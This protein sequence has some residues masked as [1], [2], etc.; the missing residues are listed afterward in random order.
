MS[1]IDLKYLCTTIGN[2][3]GVPIRIFENERLTFY[4]SQSYLPRD[5]MCVYREKI[6]AVKWGCGHFLGPLGH[7]AQG[8][9]VLVRTQPAQ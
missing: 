5:P 8:P 6:F 2:L 9:S 4:Y 1:K 7:I 3:S